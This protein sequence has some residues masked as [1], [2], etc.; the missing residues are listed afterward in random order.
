MYLL[1]TQTETLLQIFWGTR[2]IMLH[3]K[4]TAGFNKNVYGVCK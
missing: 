2:L 1:Y 4:V 3:V